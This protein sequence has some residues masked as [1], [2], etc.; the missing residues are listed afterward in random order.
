MAG[1]VVWLMDPLVVLLIV[2]F[3]ISFYAAGVF[4][5]PITHKQVKAR[6]ERKKIEKQ[7]KR[8]AKNTWDATAIGPG[9]YA[10]T[11]IHVATP[12]KPA[13][14]PLE[15]PR[16]KPGFISFCVYCVAQEG[17]PHEDWCVRKKE[18]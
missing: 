1:K 14:E 2:S 13:E 7:K 9:S 18:R 6:R 15:V 12:E 17:F 5:K 11:G 10:N 3:V 4:G 8:L 16:V